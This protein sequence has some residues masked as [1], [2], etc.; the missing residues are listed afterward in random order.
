MCAAS[1]ASR[2]RA[3]TEAVG[4]T[5]LDTQHRGPPHLMHPHVLVAGALH[6]QPL[7]GLGHGVGREVRSRAIEIGEHLEEVRPFERPDSD[8]P[9]RRRGPYVPV[10]AVESVPADV[11]D[12]RRI[13]DELGDGE[14][15]PESL[16]DRAASAIGR[17]RIAGP[18]SRLGAVRPAQ[19]Q[20]SPRPP[21][22]RSRSARSRTQ[23]LRPALRGAPGESRRCATAGAS[24]SGRTGG[25]GEVAGEH[26]AGG[27]C[28]GDLDFGGG[29]RGQ[30]HHML[31]NIVESPLVAGGATRRTAGHDGTSCTR[32][33]NRTD[34][35]HA[36]PPY[37]SRPTATHW[38]NGVRAGPVFLNRARISWCDLPEC[39]GSRKAIHIRFRLQ[40]AAGRVPAQA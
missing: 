5:G 3:D 15:H 34:S 35:G 31:R 19:P 40:E 24:R 23:R 14:A 37:R 2:T 9:A 16:A 33:A 17:D 38:V 27:P 25:G 4:Y 29:D 8:A 18:H 13:G 1:P 39:H 12:Q 30:A 11:R 32:R 28:S 36:M 20:P 10:P 21:P 7:D 22:A 6:E 26:E